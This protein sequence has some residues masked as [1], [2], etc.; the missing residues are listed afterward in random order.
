MRIRPRLCCG[1]ATLAV[2]VWL[3]L[4]FTVR[5]QPATAPA[6][7]CAVYKDDFLIGVATDF[8]GGAPLTPVELSLIK[9]QFN[10]ITPENSMKPQSVHPEENRWTW[11]SADQLVDFCQTNNILLVGHCLAWHGQTARWFFEGENGQPV[12]REKAIER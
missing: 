5:A 7:L 6:S 12:T 11:D 4:P 2:A 8:N 3:I 9:T 10:V 1:L